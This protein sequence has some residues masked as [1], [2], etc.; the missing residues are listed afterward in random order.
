MSR[1]VPSQNGLLLEAPQ[2]H[3]APVAPSIATSSA[4]RSM[5]RPSRTSGPFSRRRIVRAAAVASSGTRTL[6][7]PSFPASSNPTSACRPSQNGLLLDAPQRHRATRVCRLSGRRS[8][9][10]R[11]R[12]PVANTGPLAAT[13][14][15]FCA[16]GV[17]RSLPSSPVQESAPVGQRCTTAAI[18]SDC[19]AVASIHGLRSGSNTTGRPRTHSAA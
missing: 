6:D 17:S 1:C 9:S 7:V 16:G 13:T 8:A 10:T 3:R 2:R 5:Y 15:T 19:A 12:F 18:S 4:A 14:R 11:V